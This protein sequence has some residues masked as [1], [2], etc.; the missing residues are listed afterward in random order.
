MKL[1]PYLAKHSKAQQIIAPPYDVISLTESK[2]YL[3]KSPDAMLSITLPDS[4]DA[5]LT[6]TSVNLAQKLNQHFDL[7]N[8]Q[9][10]IIYQIETSK[11]IQNGLCCLADTDKLIKH[12][13]TQPAKV[14]NRVELL[15]SV[16]C[17]ISP[18]MLCTSPE[19]QLSKLL[20]S[21]CSNKQPYSEVN[22]NN[23]IHRIFVITEPSSVKHISEVYKKAR[24]YIADGHH[25]SQTQQFL[26]QQQPM[27]FSSHTLSVIFPGESL[28]ILGYH[29]IIKPKF[30]INDIQLWQKLAS[31]CEIEHSKSAIFPKK[32]SIIGCYYQKQWY[33]LRIKNSSINTL[34]VDI[35]H[36][37]IIEPI[38]NISDPRTDKQLSFIGGMDAN[39]K[40]ESQVDCIAES[41]AF[42]LCPTSIDDII[43]TA[44]ENRVM[45]PKSTYFEPKLLDGL[46]IQEE[47]KILT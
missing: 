34:A 13:L 22:F 46:V 44:N 39:K 47:S 24:L 37:Q 9:C 40:I 23:D 42:T 32:K 26:H 38:F 3:D 2:K 6:Q 18:I 29:R 45:P 10:F 7:I 25:R 19:L 31:I 4:I 33:S 20:S 27:N 28:N 1:N 16:K 5:N 15:E 30:K 35:L 8:S 36:D 41:I 43:R 17:Q 12:E 21:T 14:K 11:G